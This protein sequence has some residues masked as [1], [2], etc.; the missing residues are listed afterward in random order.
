[1]GH[2]QMGAAV[3]SAALT[4]PSS[5]VAVTILGLITLLLGGAYAALG[6]QLIL[7]GAG[8]LVKPGGDPW[9]QVIALGGIVPALI[10]LLGI[11]F[12]VQGLLGLLAGSGILLRKA[13]GRILTFILAVL[14]ILLGLVWVSGGDATDIALGAAQ[15][16]Y[17][18][19]A[20]V[21]LIRKGAEF[22][23]PQA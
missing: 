21:I 4:N 13:W 3:S 22:S 15:V 8:W 17:G 6:G 18:I 12:L 5:R 16:L 19:L 23:R 14:A 11:A 20:F 2:P 9:V 7:G 1:M 10:I